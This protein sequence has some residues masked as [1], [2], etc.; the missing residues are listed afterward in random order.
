MSYEDA[1]ED[2]AY[3]FHS[4]VD[5]EDSGRSTMTP[6]EI[7]E[8]FASI[9]TQTVKTPFRKEPLTNDELDVICD[10]MIRVC[11]EAKEQGTEA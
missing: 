1:R 4:A 8:E 5:G 6:T 10:R 7:M 2:M 3:R 11:D 9:V